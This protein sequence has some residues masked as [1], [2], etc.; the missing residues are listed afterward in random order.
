MPEQPKVRTTEGVV[1]GLW[2]EGHAVFRGIPYARPPVGELRFQ[3]PAPP[4]RWEGTRQ[5]TEFG[6]PVP[7]SLPID[8]G[9]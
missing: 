5:A 8:T 2:R 4:P 1:Q 3:A 6:P 9:P 7:L